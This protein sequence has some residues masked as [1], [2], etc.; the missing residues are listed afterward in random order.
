MTSLIEIFVT[1]GKKKK[2]KSSTKMNEK[3]KKKVTR[4]TSKVQH[5]YMLP[6]KKPLLRLF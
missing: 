1:E 2:K 4:A 3:K 6:S 5:E